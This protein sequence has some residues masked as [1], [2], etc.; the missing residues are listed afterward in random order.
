[1][2]PVKKIALIGDSNQE[3][4]QQMIS[5]IRSGYNPHF[6]VVASSLP[7]DP[8]A[9]DLLKERPLVEGKP[10][11]YVCEGFVCR[12]PVTELPTLR[13]VLRCFKN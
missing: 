8:Q 7:I 12:Q 2:G 5:E 13:K 10:T 6:V 3:A 11:V 9:P 4:T 1:V